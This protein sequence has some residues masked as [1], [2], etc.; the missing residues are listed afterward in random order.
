MQLSVQRKDNAIKADFVLNYDFDDYMKTMI[1][2]Q[3]DIIVYQP[4][5]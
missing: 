4:I 1:N 5:N 2:K 3:E